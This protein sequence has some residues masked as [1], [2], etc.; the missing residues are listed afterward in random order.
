MTVLYLAWQD[1]KSRAW[2]PVGRLVRRETDP[3]GY[4]FEYIRGAKH[5]KRQAGFSEI[6]GFPEMGRRYASPALFSTF[7]NRAMNPRRPDRPEYLRHLGLDGDE[8]DEVS[9][10]SVSGGRIQSDNFEMFPPI[11]PDA[12]GRFASRFMLHGL[13]HTNPDSIR[14]SESLKAGDSLVLSLELN[15]Q[16]TGYAVNVQTH[17]HYTLGWLPHYLV[18]CLHRDGAWLVEDAEAHVERVNPDAPLSHRALASFS[19][20]LRDGVNPMAELEQY[21]PIAASE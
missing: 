7:R 16:F 8:W 15:N 17:D 12:D 5:A 21:Q 9:E 13:R 19:G 11:A 1:R 18:D 4:E 6:P 20:R 2:F 10:L 3:V 14:R